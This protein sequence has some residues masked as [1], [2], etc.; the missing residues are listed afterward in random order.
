M[1]GRR[2]ADLKTLFNDAKDLE[3][4]TKATSISL[5]TMQDPHDGR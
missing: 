5:K 4:N 1:R 2:Y 3:G